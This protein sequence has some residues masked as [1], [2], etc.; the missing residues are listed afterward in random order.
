MLSLAVITKN[1]AH[2]IARCL[3]SV[4]GLAD[5]LL[6]V[7]SGSTD[8]TI[9][10]AE[11]MGARVLHHDFEGHIEQKNFASAQV[12]GD[13]ILSLDADEALNPE[14]YEAIKT[15]KAKG[16]PHTA[17]AMNRL[18][19]YLGKWI[20]HSGWYPDTKL[21]LFKKGSCAWGGY[22]PHDKLMPLDPSLPIQHLNGDI[23]HYTYYSLQEHLSQVNYF[24]DILAKANYEDG[25]RSNLLKIIGGGAFKFFK[26]FVL[27]KGFLDGYHGFLIASI[28]AFATFIKYA[29]LKR[30]QEAASKASNE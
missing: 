18:T 27:K 11:S 28:S 6:V 17:Y 16:F 26:D 24:T 29:K 13:F 30:I 8:H 15:E 9:A 12:R 22:N 4:E 7:D 21:R 23:L 19:S 10:I 20:H 25:K 1:E 2:N 5:E 3:Q 14:L